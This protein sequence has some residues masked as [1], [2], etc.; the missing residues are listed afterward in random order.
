MHYNGVNRNMYRSNQL[1][2]KFFC[3]YIRKPL[4]NTDGVRKGVRGSSTCVTSSGGVTL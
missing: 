4:L 3:S 1:K 2:W